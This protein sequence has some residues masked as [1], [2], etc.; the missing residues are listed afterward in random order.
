MKKRINRLPQKRKA[1]CFQK[2][3]IQKVLI[4]LIGFFC[5]QPIMAQ[6]ILIKGRVE[7]ATTGEEIIGANVVVKGTT[8]GAA[9]NLEG[10]FELNTAVNSTLVISYIGYIEQEIVVRNSSPL[11]IRM[12]DDAFQLGEIIAVGYGSQKKKELTGSVAG[13]K[14]GDLNKGVQTN[15][16]GM[17]QGKVA[18]LNVSKPNSGDPN[19][20]YVFQLR[21]TS[22]LQGNTTPLIIIDGIP[23]GDLSAIPQDD[24]E[25]IDILKD[26]SAAAIYGTRGTNGVIL[27]TT[28]R[29]NVGK[30]VTSYSGYASISTIARKLNMMSRE[31][32][33]ANGGNDRGSDTDWL[34]EITRTPFIHSHNLSL[35]GGSS[36]FNYRASL[37]F[38]ENPGLALK[39][40]YDELI[41]RFVANQTLLNGKVQI[42]YDATY[43]RY[44]RESS[45]NDNSA[46]KHATHFNPTAPVYDPEN[47]LSGGYYVLDIQNYS[48]PVASLKQSDNHTKGGTFQ[49]STRI[50][51]NILEGLRAQAFGSVKYTD[52]VQGRYSSRE[53]YNTSNYG[54]ATRRYDN[55]LNE[56]IETTVDYIK[57]FDKHHLVALAGYSYEHNFQ[58]WYQVQNSNFDSDVFSYYNLGAGADLLNNPTQSMMESFMTQDDLVS[59]FGRVNY[60][61]DERYL[62]SASIRHEASTRLGANH[63]WGTFPAVSAGWR[64]S[65]EEFMEGIDFIDEL[66]LRVGYGV[67]GN[68]PSDSY[69]SLSLM[70]VVG[71]FYDHTTGKWVSA[72]GPTQNLNENIKWEKKGEWNVGID[73]SGYNNRVSVTIDA[74]SRKVSDLLYTYKVP[75]PPYQYSEMLANV[76]DASSKGLELSLSVVPVK[77]KTF[78]WNSSINFSFNN[79]KIDKFSNDHF[80]TD[81]IEKGYLN[82]GDLGG[83]ENTPLLRLIPGGKVG[84]F[85]LPVFEG[86]TEEGKWIFKDINGDGKFTFDD[87]RVIVGNAQP[88]FISGW[89]NEF[90][91]KDFDLA[92]TLRA[93]V[94]NE[95]FNVGRMALENPNVAGQ[96]K[97]MLASVIGLTLMDAGL[98]SDYYLEDGSFLKMDNITLGYNVPL[99]R[100]DYISNLRAYFTAQN[101]FT[102]TGYKGVDPEVDMVGI[103]NMGIER[104]RFYPTVRS[105][106]LGI[107]VS[108]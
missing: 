63:K 29:G 92:F 64:I 84:D 62:L 51:W 13:L 25:S 36:Q 39:S 97:N 23:Q 41:G 21:G 20:D 90:T 71:R 95:V 103:D 65:N 83:L 18:G 9:T 88:D 58:E 106:V 5:F 86:F 12:E 10:N 89:T 35:T 8:N 93:I 26:G 43:R 37:S 30:T 74:Y 14:E 60:N 99:K 85:Y 7:D 81:W 3:L 98:P 16:M 107:N 50:T 56:T 53:I 2:Q 19:G 31:Q 22:S 76:G 55:W 68:M 75:T 77:N 32:F 11:T 82:S 4:V 48:N 73:W 28:K 44:N 1:S 67:T 54:Q 61:Y 47:H 70:G 91:Y 33:L 57:S 49:G 34:G 102:I 80:Q 108:F 96:E 104:T 69:K 94:G 46:F 17:M 87:D 79:N 6:D 72:Y 38:K 66:K 100:N 78:S 27:V 15:P 24:I 101:V 45:N 105:F 59:F 42:A 52:Q 40:G